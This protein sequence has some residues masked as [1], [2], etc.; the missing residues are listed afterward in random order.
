[1]IYILARD[2]AEATQWAAFRGLTPADFL[3][4]RGTS[5]LVGRTLSDQDAVVRLA[6]FHEHDFWPELELAMAELCQTNRMTETLH[7][8]LVRQGG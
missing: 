7:G 2:L 4:V 8:R 1:M 3:Y 5:S 6:R